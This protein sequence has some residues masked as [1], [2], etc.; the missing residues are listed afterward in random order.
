MIEGVPTFLNVDG[1]MKVYVKGNTLKNVGKDY[2]IKDG[3]KV[4]E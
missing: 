1:K 2:V 3:S 4:I